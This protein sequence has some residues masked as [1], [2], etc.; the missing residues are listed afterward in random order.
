MFHHQVKCRLSD[1]IHNM[2]QNQHR[3]HYLCNSGLIKLYA[4]DSNTIDIIKSRREQKI[5][6][7]LYKSI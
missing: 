1:N 6:I 7:N 4:T 2:N 5:S 3:L